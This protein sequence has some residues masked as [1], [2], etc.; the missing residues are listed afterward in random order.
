MSAS[1]LYDLAIFR[2]IAAA[3][4]E[5]LVEVGEMTRL[6]LV[7]TLKGNRLANQCS[8]PEGDRSQEAGDRRNRR[9]TPAST[10]LL[11]TPST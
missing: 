1:D 9:A 2:E 6:D 3:G 4:T 5:A 8:V 10:S 7:L 11:R